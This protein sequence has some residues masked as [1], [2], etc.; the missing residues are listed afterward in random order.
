ML[1]TFFFKVVFHTCITLYDFTDSKDAVFQNLFFFLESLLKRC[2]R[3]RKTYVFLING[4]EKIV[5]KSNPRKP[6]T[7]V[8]SVEFIKRFLLS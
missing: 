5:F 8:Y 3:Q 1:L 2:L 4:E 6:C 7:V